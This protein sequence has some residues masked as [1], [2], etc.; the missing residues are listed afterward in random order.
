MQ[1]PTL[2]TTFNSQ[3]G[4]FAAFGKSTHGSGGDFDLGVRRELHTRKGLSRIRA[5]PYFSCQMSLSW[6][7]LVC[8]FACKEHRT[9]PI[10][11]SFG[12]LVCLEGTPNSEGSGCCLEG[13]PN[14]MMTRLCLDEDEVCKS[15]NLDEWCLDLSERIGEIVS[16]S[17]YYRCRVSDTNGLCHCKQSGIRVIQLSLH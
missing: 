7:L 17:G 10:L 2:T 4:I 14:S 15:R 16:L 12:W 9:S 6:V 11:G 1:I 13:A 5:E 3:V 8:W